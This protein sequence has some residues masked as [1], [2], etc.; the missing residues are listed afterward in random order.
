MNN[1]KIG[2]VGKGRVVNGR[3]I[4]TEVLNGKG[5][6]TAVSTSNRPVAEVKPAV[7]P[8]VRR[9]PAVRNEVSMIDVPS[10]MKNRQPVAI[11]EPVNKVVSI[12]NGYQ[13][14][15]KRTLRSDAKKVWNWLWDLED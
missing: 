5:F 12:N 1:T 13:G 15:S 3:I 9:E 2:M 10:F 8:V 11:A 7:T 14:E 4:F 6:N